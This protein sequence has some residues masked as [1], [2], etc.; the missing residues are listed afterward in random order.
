MKHRIVNVTGTTRT[1]LFPTMFIITADG[2]PVDLNVKQWRDVSVLTTAITNL[3]NSGHLVVIDLPI[4]DEKFNEF[5]GSLDTEG[6]SLLA[7]EEPELVNDSGT[8]QSELLN[9]NEGSLAEEPKQE[10]TPITTKPKEKSK[11]KKKK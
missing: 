1:G 2:R 9:D 5:L 7:V 8:T 4:S 6:P 11:D 3:R 10:P